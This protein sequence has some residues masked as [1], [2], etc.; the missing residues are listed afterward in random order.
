MTELYKDNFEFRGSYYGKNKFKLYKKY[1]I[2]CTNIRDI[3]CDVNNLYIDT[4]FGTIHHNFSSLSN[5]MPS[6]SWNNVN[7][8]INEIQFDN[9]NNSI[10]FI[11]PKCKKTINDLVDCGDEEILENINIQIKFTPE[12]Y[13]KILPMLQH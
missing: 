7:D 1:E 9:T 4:F 13:E 12:G 11:V 3:A 2:I 8:E 5:C 6:Y 10:N